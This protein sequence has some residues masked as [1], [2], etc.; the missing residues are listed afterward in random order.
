MGRIDVY[1]CDISKI[2]STGRLLKRYN[3]IVP[4]DAANRIYGIK[5]DAV[6]R[7]TVVGE[8]FSRVLLGSRLGIKPGE[9]EVLKT[10]EGKPYLKNHENIFFNL[11]HSGGKVV[12]AIGETRLGV[13]IE[14]ITYARHKVAKKCFCDKEIGILN[15]SKDLN[16]EFFRL[17]TMKEAYLKAEGLGLSIPPKSVDVVSIK[18][19]DFVCAVVDDAYC[20]SVC[21][22]DK[23]RV[24][25]HPAGNIMT[26]N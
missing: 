8:L 15:S 22:P 21:A 9:L 23:L 3:E 12:C 25:F 2:K 18:S 17:W 11:S 26:L 7:R 24:V 13:D 20:L 10:R 1:I 19:H 6:L 14:K 16:K 5:N 4:R